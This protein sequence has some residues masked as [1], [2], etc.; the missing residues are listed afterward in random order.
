MRIFI[1]VQYYDDIEFNEKIRKV[2]D[3]D[4]NQLNL[5]NENDLA[6]LEFIDRNKNHPFATFGPAMR[7][8]SNTSNG[9]RTQSQ[10]MSQFDEEQD[11]VL[12]DGS[13]RNE[14]ENSNDQQ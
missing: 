14:T 6:Q 12:T 7:T 1:N 2:K 11:N 10:I 9:N 4:V 8:F 3:A 5:E 13:P